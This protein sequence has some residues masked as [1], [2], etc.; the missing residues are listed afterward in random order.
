M[1]EETKVQ[2]LEF[3]DEFLLGAAERRYESGDYL[4]ALT[5]LNKRSGLFLPSADAAAL[6]GDIYETLGVWQQCEDAWFRFLDTCNEA[7]FAEGYEGLFIAF[8]N[9]GDDLR[10]ELYYRKAYSLINGVSELDEF[11]SMQEVQRP[12]LRI[13][14][15]DDGS[16]GDPELL[17]RGV[18]YV[19]IGSLNKARE[20][21]SEIPPESLDYPSAKGLSAMCLLLSGE[22]E[23]A[24]EEC[25]TLLATHPDNIHALTTYCAVLGAQ[26]K[27]EEARAIGRRLSQIQTDSLEDTYRIATALCETGL[28]E[29]AYHKLSRL[30]EKEP[31]D[32]N[33]LWF[34]AVAAFRTGRRDQAISTLET[35][36]TI[37]PKKEVAR[38]Y[39]EHLREDS[40]SD[41]NYF[42]RLPQEEYKTVSGFLL[43]IDSLHKK[44]A[45]L[46]SDTDELLRN[47]RVA[48]DHD[49]GHDTQLQLLAAKVCCNSR[50]DNILREI[51]ISCDVN[52]LVKMN[53]LR[54][55]VIRNEDD[56]FGVVV[57]DFYREVFFHKLD[58]A[59]HKKKAFLKA[60][61]EVYVR[62]AL[63]GDDNEAKLVCAAEN[64]NKTLIEA[65]AEDS[66]FE[67]QEALA[68]VIFREARLSGTERSIDKIASTFEAN[69]NT[70]K[71]ILNYLI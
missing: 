64:V 69:V 26:D 13:I 56:S 39:L 43:M 45:E 22:T 4:G 52:E 57:C 19:K 38:Y 62:F 55:L 63:V 31:Y 14:H 59:Q 17:R 10:A 11:P 58:L 50:S 21:L 32:D 7:D 40:V 67:E 46:F 65:E 42:Y 37:Y 68:A 30:I 1:G 3:S 2:K 23:Q 9:L 24:A 28:D 54:E 47:V 71:I 49:D 34:Y 16:V 5:M 66:L 44:E 60:F 33:F 8:S 61:A 70:V 6:Y 12:K 20:I 35:L 25:R 53:I 18:M 36:T 29:E 27:K 48:F 41:M 15:S 51:L